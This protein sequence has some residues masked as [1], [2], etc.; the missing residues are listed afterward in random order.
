MDWL[1]LDPRQGSRGM[2]TRLVSH[3]WPPT[4]RH[5]FIAAILLLFVGLSVQY[6]FKAI[7]NRGAISRWFQELL[8]DPDGLYK[9]YHF[10]NPPITALLLRPLAGLPPV[11][12][13]LVWFYLKVG[14]TLA[15][16]FWIFRLV[17]DPA[18]PFPEWAKG[19]AV[20]LSLRPIMGDLS[21]GNINLFILF[22]VIAA[23]Y[24]FHR[25]RSLVGGL[26]L[27][28]A[29]ACKVTP[30]LFL[31]YLLWKRAWKALAGC[32]LGLVLFL[33]VV[34]SAFLGW[35]ENAQ[36][37]HD[38]WYQMVVPYVV[39]GE[40]TSEHN[41]QSLPG[42]ACRLLTHRPS[43]SDYDEHGVYRPLEYHNLV[44]EDPTVVRWLVKGCMLLFAGTVVWSCRTRSGSG[45]NWR[46]AAE[47]SIVLLGMLL[48]SE[49]TW[50]HHCVTMTLPFAVLC[51]HF[52]AC[53]AKVLL[54]GYLAGTLAGVAVLMALT[55]TA[56]LDERFAKLAQV[57]GA[58][59]WGYL[60][61]VAA[62]VVLL[63]R[64][65]PAVDA[66]QAFRGL[67]QAA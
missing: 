3:F 11:A 7:D 23:L 8:A 66:A 21:H 55:S 43:F 33:W 40:V 9:T 30:A 10:P 49:R 27:G 22:L 44:T 42:L 12:G 6:T 25:Q 60:L 61:C 62:L 17:E 15:S 26:V 65:G 51:Y 52:T 18:R 50:K 64:P 28:L 41:N 1:R 57:Y 16:L 31:P 5:L 34:P 54:R 13:A 46:I 58:Y 35:S 4:A 67:A 36:Q 29:I 48:F 20:L 56:L 38:W 59:V 39:N 19:L 63:R 24:A 32:T 53:K 47:Y 14:M 37:L 45:E 2:N